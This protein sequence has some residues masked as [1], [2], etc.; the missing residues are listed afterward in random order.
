MHSEQEHVNMGQSI[1]IVEG[2]FLQLVLQFCCTTCIMRQVAWGIVY[3]VALPEV[4]LF[5]N[6]NVVAFT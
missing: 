6:V 5:C 3:S 2:S 1:Y 4:N